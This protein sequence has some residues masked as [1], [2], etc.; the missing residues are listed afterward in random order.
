[1][2]VPQLRATIGSVLFAS[3]PHG[4]P[5][6]LLGLGLLA[7]GCPL[8]SV[9]GSP[10]DDDATDDDDDATDDDDAADDDDALDDDD[11]ADDDLPFDLPVAADLDPDPDVVSVV[12]VLEAG[13]ASWVPGLTTPAWL[14][15]GRSPGPRIEAEVGQT[16]RVQVENRL[17][18]PTTLH[19]HGLETPAAMSGTVVSQ[20]P[21]APGDVFVYE[22][23]L[24]R[25]GTAWYRSG[26]E[27]HLQ[28]E[29]GLSGPVV[30][31]DPSE[32]SALGLPAEHRVLLFDDVDL[33]TGG[34]LT[35]PWPFDDSAPSAMTHGK[36]GQHLLVNGL[37][38]PTMTAAV[39]EPVRLRLLNGANARVARIDV[40]G[41][42][43]VRV[44]GDA[45]LLSAPELRGPIPQIA[46]PEVGTVSDPDLSWGLTL[47][48]GDRADVV[49]VP[50]GAP[51]DRLAI[52]WHDWPRGR[53]GFSANGDMVLEPGDGLA[54]PRTVAW[55][56]LTDGSESGWAPPP[57]LRPI[58]LLDTDGARVEQ[59][60][61]SPNPGTLPDLEMYADPLARPFAA[62]PPG[63]GPTF[64]VGET[65]VLEVWNRIPMIH[66]LHVAGFVF[67]P[68][69]LEYVDRC[70]PALPRTVIE[71]WAPEWHDTFMLPAGPEGDSCIQAI[72]TLAIRFDDVGREGQIAASGKTPTADSA[73]GWYL[74][75]NILEHD[76]RGMATFLQIE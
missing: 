45:G 66:P 21:I 56:E 40:E 24:L 13:E 23:P 49:V 59:L 68:L 7:A 31:R 35:G 22:F 19:W 41:Q 65:A 14:I 17:P 57:E 20:P 29:A 72:T 12:L 76:A 44:G 60:I 51:G 53:M 15:N 75:C 55:I 11:G 69:A 39:G 61:F 70:D 30:V 16:L 36:E 48:P 62:I 58:G 28:V 2:R 18:E 10:D 42:T 34:R 6:L 46:H 32:D 1:V 38:I 73:G 74:Q 25:A 27:P 3:P 54:P 8:P 52:R 37:T 67:Q 9:V 71:T 33:T 43:L 47:V 63:D 4:L 64:S 50:V 26:Y 5:W